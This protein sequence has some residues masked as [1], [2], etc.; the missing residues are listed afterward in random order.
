MAKNEFD[1]FSDEEAPTATEHPIKNQSVKSPIAAGAAGTTYDWTTAPSGAARVPRV[2]LNGQ[3][4]LVKDVSIILPP[5]TQPW[6]KSR[7]GDKEL[8]NCVFTLF[9]DLH[10]QSEN[11][12]G[13]R[14]FKREENGE[15]KYSHPTIPKDRKCQASQLFGKY[16]DFKKKTLN[17]CSLHE[18][19]AFL[20]SQPK[21]KIIKVAF[22]N[23]DTGAIVEK[24]MVDEF[25]NP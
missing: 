21:A 25:L 17:E 5:T 3:T 4:V 20:H 13:V 19:L 12:S 10:S 16:A 18:F 22:T 6:D 8:K 1:E 24:N 14:V 15:I 7:K 23:P 11:Y 9:Y 2:D